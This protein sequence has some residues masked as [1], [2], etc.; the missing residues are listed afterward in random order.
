[1]KTAVLISGQLREFAR[2]YPGQRWMVYRHHEPCE[3]F[4]CVQRQPDADEV[5]APLR[6]DYP[7]RVHVRLLDDPELPVTPAMT[8]GWHRAPFANAAPLKNLLLQHWYQEK[9]WDFFQAESCKLKAESSEGYALVM[10][11]RADNLW[12][13]YEPPAR[14]LREVIRLGTEAD[15]LG[16]EILVP[17]WGG[18]GG[19]N[20]RWALMAAEDAGAY[21][22]VYS[23]IGRLLE[24]GCP[25]HPESLTKAAVET[26]GSCF[27]RV[28]AIF[29][30]ARPKGHPQHPQRWPEILPWEKVG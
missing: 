22:R 15:R 4:I 26:A 1:M 18:F 17:W 2:C 16:G 3:F 6:R 24:A 10:R 20:D 14:D 8:E 21:F 25:F 23:S 29:S 30:T 12:H 7:G 9:V 5:L 19:V 28:N 27:S 13:H 11:M